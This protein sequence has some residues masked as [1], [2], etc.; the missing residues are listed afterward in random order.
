M[1]RQWSL[2]FAC[3]EMAGP[4]A[5]ARTECA[6]APLHVAE[7]QLRRQPQNPKPRALQPPVPARIRPPARRRAVVAPIHFHDELPRRSQKV[8]DAAG[9]YRLAAKPH[10]EL[11][12]SKLG[13][14]H[15]LRCGGLA[16]HGARKPEP[17][18]ELNRR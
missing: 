9:H 13:P 15:A 18:S 4:L 11:G 6:E 7:H 2:P 14:Q 16:A 5:R 3:S 17:T 1:S 8:H 10:A 12:A